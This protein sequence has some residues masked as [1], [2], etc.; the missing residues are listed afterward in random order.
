[1]SLACRCY[2][3][4]RDW[5][6]VC[7]TCSCFIHIEVQ[8][9][10]RGRRSRH[11]GSRGGAIAMEG[12]TSMSV[13][14]LL[15]FHSIQAELLLVPQMCSRMRSMRLQILNSWYCFLQSPILVASSSARHIPAHLLQHLLVVVDVDDR[16]L[17]L[18][19][20]DMALEQ[21]VDLAVG[22]AL[23]LWQTPPGNDKTDECRGAPDVPTLAANYSIVSKTPL[24]IRTEL[25]YSR[26]T[27]SGF[28]MY[29]ARKMQGISTM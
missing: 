9:A 13:N 14:Q 5:T 17:P 19:G 6:L 1:M 16:L 4:K 20:R 27:P 23:H 18:A 21:D 7:V 10:V 3:V 8:V 28:S 26:L 2:R 29:C 25:W 15:E 22:A 12:P 24:L 11:Y